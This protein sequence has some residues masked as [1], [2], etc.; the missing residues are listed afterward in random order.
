MSLIF[1]RRLLGSSSSVPAPVLIEAYRLAT[2]ERDSGLLGDITRHSAAPGSLLESS[3]TSRKLEVRA[4]YY[5][6]TEEPDALRLESIRSEKAQGALLL[7]TLDPQAHPLALE[8]AA[9]VGGALVCAQVIAHARTTPAVRRGALVRLDQQHSQLTSAQQDQV[10]SLLSSRTPPA[11]EGGEEPLVFASPTVLRWCLLYTSLPPEE[12]DG[13]AL[14]VGGHWEAL[15]GDAQVPALLPRFSA[16]VQNTFAQEDSR[17]A[18][19]RH[20]D[21]AVLTSGMVERVAEQVLKFLQVQPGADMRVQALLQWYS[22]ASLLLL[23]STRGQ[24][25]LVDVCSLPGMFLSQRN[26]AYLLGQM[27]QPQ[28]GRM[29]LD[30]GGELEELPSLFARAAG[31]SDPGELLDF[32]SGLPPAYAPA[33]MVALVRN[34]HLTQEHAMVLARSPHLGWSEGNSLARRFPDPTTRGT[35]YARGLLSADQLLSGPRGSQSILAAMDALL[36]MPLPP[37]TATNWRH[38]RD[39]RLGLVIQL[40]RSS[41]P[42]PVPGLDERADQFVRNLPARVALEGALHPTLLTRVG[43]ILGETLGEDTRRWETYRVLSQDCSAS[44]GELLDGVVAVS[45]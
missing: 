7:L 17:V 24:E 44:F 18:L 20:L 27:V 33:L 6:R 4:A 37:S 35:L 43:L 22:T 1:Y 40:L 15:K 21:M 38:T 42:T 8:A 34:P 39:S 45:G 2:L 14:Q 13:V 3:R 9:E 36:G 10:E 25:L 5:S 23:A 12:R 41:E 29:L 30:R 26:D 19:L 16:H 11:V 32:V 28:I 31:L